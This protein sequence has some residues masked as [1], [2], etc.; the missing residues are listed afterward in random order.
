MIALLFAWFQ[1]PVPSAPT[2][3]APA[4]TPAPVA[5][6]PAP[7]P[8]LPKF[9]GPADGLS[10][11]QAA[12]GEG[13]TD[14]ALGLADALL[15][16]NAWSKLRTSFEGEHAWVRRGFDLVEPAVA[17]FG[18]GGLSSAGRGEIHYAAGVALD[19]GGKA[20][21]AQAR[22]RTALALAGPGALRLDA[23]YDVGAISLGLA[24][25]LREAQQNA[26]LPQGPAPKGADPLDA[27][28]NA[29]RVAR[30]ELVERLRADWHGEDTRA[31]LE[32]IQRR[33]RE[34]EAQRKQQQEDQQKQ[35]SQDPNQKQDP[36]KKD[37]QKQDS[38]DSK[39]DKSDQD[40]SQEK[41]DGSKPDQ[42]Q[43]DEKKDQQGKDEKSDEQKTDEQKK[44]DEQKSDAEKAKDEQAQKADEKKDDVAGEPKPGEDERVLTREEV[45]RILSQLDEIEKEGKALEA[46]LRRSR[47][48]SAEKDW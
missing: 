42:P 21:E 24:E 35:Q 10:S 43:S 37:D 20:A 48:R 36:D 5:V 11:L 2:Q 29:Y 40:P 1:A 18:L 39:P 27:L 7:K 17:A 3:N 13:K 26:P 33:L 15:A 8:E 45:M 12:V 46:R 44:A 25:R 30:N 34:I 6:E 28:E 22:F 47:H 4:Q 19:R 38:K 9:D 23:G 31:N 32:F 14:V 41:K 16:P